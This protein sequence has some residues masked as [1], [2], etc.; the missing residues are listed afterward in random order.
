MNWFVYMIRSKKGM[1]YTGITN[2]LLRRFKEHQTSSR[3]AKFFRFDPPEE[4][5]YFEIIGSRSLALKREIEIK[6][7]TKQKKLALV[8]SCK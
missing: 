5:V 4:V 6:K 7:M 2:H 8:N 3:G 1:L